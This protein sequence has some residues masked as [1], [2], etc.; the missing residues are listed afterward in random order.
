MMERTLT[1]VC[2]RHCSVCADVLK[3]RLIT[4]SN[5]RCLPDPSHPL[6][7]VSE[8]LF[9]MPFD[10]GYP[11]RLLFSKVEYATHGEGRDTRIESRPI[12]VYIKY[13]LIIY[14]G[15]AFPA[16]AN[17]CEQRVTVTAI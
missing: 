15:Q 1:S 9:L 16:T 11:A 12:T 6:G 5:E 14:D 2:F 13:Q 7:P 17:V 4:A 10:L 3:A 8:L